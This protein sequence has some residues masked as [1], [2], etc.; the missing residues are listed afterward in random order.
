MI[1]NNIDTISIHP[2]TFW[3]EHQSRFPAIT[4]LTHNTLSFPVTNARVKRLFNIARDIYHY[5]R[6]RIKS[7]TVEDLMMFLYISRFNMEEQ[8]KDLLKQFFSHSEI[9]ATREKKDEKLDLVENLAISDTKEQDQDKGNNKDLIELDLDAIKQD[10][11]P[12]PSLPETR[13]QIRAS[14]RKRKSR[15]DNLFEYH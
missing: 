3:K 6:G 13:T 11:Q 12:K 7:E 5:R 1:T 4:A 15:E 14:G 2:L 10:Q 9:E 8:E